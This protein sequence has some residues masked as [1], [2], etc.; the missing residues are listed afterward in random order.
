MARTTS[1]SPRASRGRSLLAVATTAL[2]AADGVVIAPMTAHAAEDSAAS[3]VN[4]ATMD[5]G[6]KSSFRN[7]L[8]GSIAHGSIELLGTTTADAEMKESAS[9]F[10]WSSGTGTASADGSGLNVSFGEGNGVHLTGHEMTV[11]GV[12]GDALDMKFTNPRIEVESASAAMLY[13]DV[14]SREF[15]GMTSVSETFFEE[16]NVAVANIALPE[17]EQSGNTLTWTNAATTM[18]EQ[19]AVAFGGFYDAGTALDALTFS[20]TV[21]EPAV[22]TT[23]SLA[24]SATSVDVGSEVTLTATVDPAEASGEV[25]FVNGEDEL[26]EAVLVDGG[27]A[28]LTTDELAEGDHSITAAF[29]PA[30]AA[31][32]TA[33]T[34]SAVTVTVEAET[35]ETADPSLTVTPSENLDPA[36]ENVL[37][38]QGTGYVGEGCGQRRV[39][40]VW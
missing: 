36:V 12:T 7:Y 27:E 8:L 18:T 38:V 6:V 28:V 33:S 22:T 9:Q 11:D 31:A 39:R 23:T 1:R 10:H 37:T 15:E 19:G 30:D 24:A 35:V 13:F 14:K 4:E 34:S 32:Y 3:T 25:Q 16:D 20:A 29:T 5:W 17:V 26:G 2:L 21:V 40:A